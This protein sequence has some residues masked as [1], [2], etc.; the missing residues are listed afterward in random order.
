MESRTARI[1]S[2]LGHLSLCN[3]EQVIKPSLPR[4]AKSD[5][6]FLSKIDVGTEDITH[7]KG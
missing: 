5:E 6:R 4:F 2:S 1:P 3:V 7:G